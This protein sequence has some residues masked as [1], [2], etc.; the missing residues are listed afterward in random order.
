MFSFSHAN[1]GSRCVFLLAPFCACML[2][3]SL[4]AAKKIRF[5]RDVRPILSDKCFQCHG[6]DA[7]AREAD[8]RL[9][10]RESALAEKAFQ[11][12]DPDH[13]E[14]IARVS[15]AD[16]DEVMPP[17]KTHKR[18]TPEEIETLTQWIEQG[19][20]YEPHWSFIPVRKS[21]APGIASPW[22]QN[23]ID[24]F[25]LARLREQKLKPSPPAGRRTLVRRV[26]LDLTGLP[27]TPAEIDA[28]LADAQPGAYE[29]LVDRLLASPRY[30]EHIAYQWLDIARYADSDGYESDPLR[31]MWPWRDW[32]IESLNA[33]MPYDRFITE[34]LAGDLLENSTLRQRL[35]S[36]FNRNHRLNNEGGITP[37]EWIVEYR[38]DRAETAATAFLGLTWQCARCHDHK[39]DPI[40][41]VDYYSLYA[42]FDDIEEKGSASGKNAPPSMDVPALEHF[43][44]YLEVV[45][46]IA[47]MQ[48]ELDALSKTPEFKKA[49]AAWLAEIENDEEARKKLPGG[50]GSTEFKKWTAATKNLA[51]THFLQFIHAP[52]DLQKKFRPLNNRLTQLRRTGAK[53][54]IMEELPEPREAH[55]LERGAWD[56]PRDPVTA[57]TPAFLPPM[58]KD[59]PR[60]RLGLAMWL[61]NPENPLTSRVAVN[62][63]W[64]RYFGVG[65]VETQEDFG[66]QGESPSHPELLDYLARRFVDSGWDVKALQKFIVM[67]AT[68][69][70][71]SSASPALAAADPDN[72]LLARGPRFRLPANVIR[73]QALYASGLLVEKSGGPPV[74]PY[75]P[76][77]LWREIIKGRAEYTQDTGENLYRRS[78]YTLWRRAVNPP[79]M[80]LLDANGRDLCA[81]SQG[82]TNTPLQ[83]LLLL[84][85]V[86]FVETARGLATRMLKS[87]ADTEKDRLALGMR[88]VVGR[89]A[90]TEE[91]DVLLTELQTQRERFS[92]ESEKAEQLVTV[93]ES[94]P[95]PD[96]DT[97]ELAAY[98][99]VA[100]VMLNLDETLSKQ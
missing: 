44:E 24:S 9:D 3:T 29:R 84:N 59:L 10:I 75:Q 91:G 97:I 50:L 71:D 86:T 74:K 36:G 32:V 64:E 68:Y 35:A 53:V 2:P 5:N 4:E 76:E 40:T 73:D 60:N 19:A 78:F 67:S 21:R 48:K 99:A 98:T 25:V 61:T 39:Y 16:P 11:P 14:L 6:P 15:H 69:C 82:R 62:R 8:L 89:P 42:F 80:S 1:A 90:T 83:A 13:S 26:S 28:F 66:L 49:H 51:R 18:V 58:A 57:N 55:I 41:Q 38:C 37:E 31:T 87:K 56:Q 52:P 46:R 79:L 94:E 96:I 20:E 77:G 33:N 88:L 47:P 65:L 43:E 12:G 100:R 30:G 17:P 34:Q 22:I 23:E 93:G 63:F 81:V 54:M 70:Q 72:R 27:P 7:A 92:R 45:E 85:D 95:D